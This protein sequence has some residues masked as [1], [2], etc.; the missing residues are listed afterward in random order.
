MFDLL[1]V[2]RRRAIK[3]KKVAL[4]TIKVDG[5]REGAHFSVIDESGRVGD[6]DLDGLEELV[7]SSLDRQLG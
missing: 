2:A 6:T 3:N 4:I 5:L 1:E 7:V